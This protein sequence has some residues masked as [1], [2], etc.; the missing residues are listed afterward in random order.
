MNRS[1]LIA[2]GLLSLLISGCE[3]ATAPAPAPAE[4]KTVFERIQSGELQSFEKEAVDFI[5]EVCQAA[6]DTPRFDSA[7][8]RQILKD[9]GFD[10]S[11]I[12]A[13]EAK[14][15]TI[16]GSFAGQNFCPS[17]LRGMIKGNI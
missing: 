17:I 10:L 8:R 11:T 12:A 4:T 1:A 14:K 15:D 16:W 6:G 3:Q 7:A 2:L 9:Y 5:E 13:V